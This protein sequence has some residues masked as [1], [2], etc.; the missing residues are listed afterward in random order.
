MPSNNYR[1]QITVK[2]KTIFT[3]LNIIYTTMINFLF[4][5]LNKFIF[6]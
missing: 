5:Q 4:F 1:S 3:S 2:L 6:Y